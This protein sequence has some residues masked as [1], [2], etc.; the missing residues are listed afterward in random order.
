VPRLL[1]LSV[2]LLLVIAK[3]AGA[4]DR[5][6]ETPALQSDD[7]YL[8]KLLAAAE[9]AQLDRDPYWR[10]LLHYKRGLFGLRSLVDDPKFF[11]DPNGQK[12]PAA[13][14]SATLRSF[15]TPAGQEKSGVC[16][17]LA[18][19]EW[20]RGKLSIDESRLPAPRCDRFEEMFAEIAP[21]SVSLSFPTSHMNSP[22]SMYGHTLLTIEAETGS[23]LLSYAVNYSAVTTE[24][25][26]PLYIAYG[27]LG[28]YPGYFSILPYY[29]KLQ[30]YSDVND[31]DIW[32]YPLDL[33]PDEI[34][35]LVLHIFELEDIYSNYF[36]FTENCS[37]NLLFLLDVA[38]PGLRLT[39]EF[40][41]WVIPLDTIRAV[42]ETGLIG[43]AIYRPSK[44]TKISY[45]GSLLGPENREEALDIARGRIDPAWTLARDKTHEEKVQ[46][47]D[48]ASEYL[49]YIYANKEI[50]K[51]EYIPLFLKTLEARSS[52]GEADEWRYTVPPPRSRPDEGHLSNRVSVGMGWRDEDQTFQELK[53][54]PVY[55]DL[56]DS[57]QGYKDG[58][59]I[60]FL[61]TT[62]RY[63]EARDEVELTE[64]NLI[65][66]VSIAP[67][68]AFF[69]PTSW[70]IRTGFFR[71]VFQNDR[72][73]LIYSLSP[74]FGWAAKSRAL[75]L[76][77]AMLE[78][79]LQLGGAL[80]RGFS[81]GAGATVGI[82]QSWTNAWKSHVFARGLAY[83]LGDELDHIQIGVGQSFRLTTNL[84]LSV[85]FE[86]N[87]NHEHST[88]ETAVR[89]RLFF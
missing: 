7:P 19:Y 61:E 79:D 49:Q 65:D 58:S 70:K 12:D 1:L 32:E 89:G 55:H 36:F 28:L 33:T 88:L 74:G 18:R 34:R 86:R 17:F 22:A 83:R 23:A 39:D 9:Q 75:G 8:V 5:A 72:D 73:F 2:L 41:W 51:K 6:A 45:L 37:Y 24:T 64:L 69:K 71:R 43:E 62:L 25:F 76:S 31:R 13:E 82:V 42:A 16:R 85:E 20:L 53:F 80:R 78:T 4:S 87:T 11:A 56:L 77:Y 54:R 29:A 47:C 68:N 35:R 63:E 59:Q 27:L 21:K 15:F 84:N 60:V 50:R 52:L 57:G 38:R 66:I 46:I 26:G 14:L 81:G 40:G 10:T 30:Q 48:L 44:S 3:S 67:R